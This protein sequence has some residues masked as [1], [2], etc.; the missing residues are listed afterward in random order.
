MEN[1]ENG[2]QPCAFPDTF[3]RL[4]T[5]PPGLAARRVES[6][7]HRS[8]VRPPEIPKQLLPLRPVTAPETAQMPQRFGNKGTG[9]AQVIRTRSSAGK[10]GRDGPGSF[11]APSASA[12]PPARLAAAAGRSA[13]PSRGSGAEPRARQSSLILAPAFGASPARAGNHRLAWLAARGERAWPRQSP[14]WRLRPACRQAPSPAPDAN[15][16]GFAGVRPMERRR[17]ARRIACAER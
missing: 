7:S 4:I 11:Q 16:D 10:C 9:H 15:A 1:L 8:A 3:L 6:V 12:E 14:E 2:G 5:I 17:A 13:S